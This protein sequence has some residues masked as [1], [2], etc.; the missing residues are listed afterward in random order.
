M[1]IQKKHLPLWY[2]NGSG[3]YFMRR[4]WSARQ[5]EASPD[6]CDYT[7]CKIC[8]EDA[9]LLLFNT[10]WDIVTNPDLKE[11]ETAV[12]IESDK[13]ELHSF[14]SHTTWYRPHLLFPADDP[15]TRYTD[16]ELQLPYMVGC[17]SFEHPPFIE[18]D[19]HP[20]FRKFFIPKC[21]RLQEGQDIVYK[22][23][24]RTEE[25]D[26]VMLLDN[27]ED[28]KASIQ[29]L[30]NMMADTKADEITWNHR[31]Q[32]ALRMLET[33]ANELHIL[34]EAGLYDIA[35]LWSL[36]EYYELPMKQYERAKKDLLCQLHRY[37]MFAINLI[38]W[39]LGGIDKSRILPPSLLAARKPQNK[40]A[41]VINTIQTEKHSN[42][43]L[44]KSESVSSG[45]DWDNVFPHYP[46]PR[47]EGELEEDYQNRR[48]A[49]LW[50]NNR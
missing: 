9:D 32:T 38:D 36:L 21:G 17:F 19:Y 30:L 42:T 20:Q 4:H 34:H 28:L 7:L 24:L 40:V 29:N 25:C 44:S 39:I 8:Q 2:E 1:D 41:S 47:K 13:P 11:F 49:W 22:E 18:G 23:F 46:F 12:S 5:T 6:L 48:R 37:A 27:T 14:N 15:Y 10:V 45:F 43:P 3:N 33:H 50:H 16:Y 31:L 26:M 35:S